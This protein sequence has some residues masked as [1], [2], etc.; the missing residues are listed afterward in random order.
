MKK[1][2]LATI[3]S[4]VRKNR[5]SIYIRVRSDFNGMSDMVERNRNAQF[6]KAVMGEISDH[7]LGI[8]GAW[9][10]LQSRDIFSTFDN[11][12]FAG[13]HVYNCCGSFDLVVPKA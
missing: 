12:E 13:Y 10:V 3:K 4:F 8:E 2:T 9:F 1:I 11:G 5:E 6:K 7:D